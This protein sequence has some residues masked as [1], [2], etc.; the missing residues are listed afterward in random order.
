MT[1]YFHKAKERGV[2]RQPNR[3]C[4]LTCNPGYVAAQFSRHGNCTT[5]AVDTVVLS[6]LQ[7]ACVSKI[8]VELATFFPCILTTEMEYN[9]GCF[10]ACDIKCSCFIGCLKF[11]SSPFWF[12]L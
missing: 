12:T 10:V 7:V 1:K 6:K 4:H 8:T 9:S 2:Q 5:V 11:L 3:S